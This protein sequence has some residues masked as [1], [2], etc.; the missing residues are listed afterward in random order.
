VKKNVE[1]DPASVEA[2]KKR[3]LWLLDKRDYSR[4]ELLKKLT[5]KGY[6]EETAAAAVDRLAE[7]GFVDDARYAPIVVRH[8]AAKGYGARRVQAELQRRGIPK[9][10]WDAAMEEMPAQ[11]ESVDKLL[12]SRMRGAESTDRAAL[13]RAADALLRRGYAWDEINAAVERYRAET[14]ED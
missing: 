8:Y 1:F 6:A 9:E 3:A 13:K 4:A 10:L 7:L 12:R 14:E 11:D 5:E 2:A